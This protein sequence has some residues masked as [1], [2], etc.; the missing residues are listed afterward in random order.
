VCG[1]FD[2]LARDALHCGVKI[3]C[4]FDRIMRFSKVHTQASA[5]DTSQMCHVCLT[6]K[7]SLPLKESLQGL[8]V[9]VQ[10]IDEEICFKASVH[11]NIYEL[12]HCRA[13]MHSNVYNHRCVMFPPHHHVNDVGFSHSKLGMAGTQHPVVPEP[14]IY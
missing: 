12:Y 1:R 5:V 2:Y 4:D 9:H 13:Q 7:P 14:G 10:V 8:E 3:S 11:S 6:C